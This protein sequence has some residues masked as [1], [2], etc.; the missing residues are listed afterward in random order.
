[1]GFFRAVTLITL[2]VL[3]AFFWVSLG[4]SQVKECP[5][6]G[7][8]ENWLRPYPVLGSWYHFYVDHQACVVDEKA[9]LQTMAASES[10]SIKLNQAQVTFEQFYVPLYHL[11]AV[12]NWVRMDQD[13]TQKIQS[14]FLLIDHSLAKTLKSMSSAD[15]DYFRAVVLFD[16]PSEF[17]QEEAEGLAPA[18]LSERINREG[19]DL[20]RPIDS[21][22]VASPPY[23]RT[24][25]H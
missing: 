3:L 19:D 14:D 6:Y 8:V 23:E 24:F 17:V 2:W 12:D 21:R 7:E 15:Q 18:T 10:L 25:A 5:N 22:D 11:L 1:M 20:P 9:F 13:E 16:L 4:Q